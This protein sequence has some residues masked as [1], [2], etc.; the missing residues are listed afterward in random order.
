MSRMY[1]QT[2]LEHVDSRK[3]KPLIKWAGG[4]TRL[5]SILLQT[6]DLALES[7]NVKKFNYYEP[8]FGG[9]ALFFELSVLTCIKRCSEDNIKGIKICSI[10]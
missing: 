1:K 8:F 9:G 6:A 5:N 4:K 7:L 10:N 2:S 3:Y